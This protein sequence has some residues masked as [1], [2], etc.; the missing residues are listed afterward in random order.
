MASIR[1]ISSVCEPDM[2]MNRRRDRVPVGRVRRLIGTLMG[3]P[4]SLYMMGTPRRSIDREQ[5][6]Y[7]P[8]CE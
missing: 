6:Q 7:A 8:L 2:D 5:Q 3:Y 4:P 1:I